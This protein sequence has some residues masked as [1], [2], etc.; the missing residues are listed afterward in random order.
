MIAT[1][2]K[3]DHHRMAVQT[4]GKYRRPSES[5]FTDCTVSDLSA[6]GMLLQVAEPIGT[7]EILEITIEPKNKITPA[8]HAEAEVIRCEKIDGHHDVACKITKIL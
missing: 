4:E 8:L 5:S 6:T 7:G 3:R 2:N 1:D